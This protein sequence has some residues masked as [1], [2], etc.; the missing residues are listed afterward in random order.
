MLIKRLFRTMLYFGVILLLAISCLLFAVYHLGEPGLENEAGVIIVDKNGEI[1]NKKEAGQIS[2]DELPTYLIDG[3]LLAE[4]RHFYDHYG[5]YLRGIVRAIL[6]IFDQRKLK[7][8]P[9]TITQQLARNL[10]LTH[11]KT[12]IRKIKQYFYSLRIEMFYSKD[13]IIETYL[14]SIYFGH[15][16]Y[17]IS[18]ASQFYFGKRVAD[19]SVAEAT[20]LIGIPRGPTYYSPY[21]NIDNATNRQQFI[22]DKLFEA[23]KIT[24]ADYHLAKGEELQFLDKERISNNFAGYF[25]DYVWQELTEQLQFTKEQL[26]QQNVTIH[27]TLDGK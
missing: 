8:G 4:D 9:S 27:T 17:G 14:N 25:I 23:G 11:E 7:Q 6:R 20:M 13:T 3:Y 24:A 10:Y 1:L 15:G 19:L 26:M 18:E 22:L 21:N 12:W 16:A 2:L 5:F